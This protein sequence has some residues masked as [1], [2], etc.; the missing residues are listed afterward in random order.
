MRQ[1]TAE[2]SALVRGAYLTASLILVP[3]LGL[4]QDAVMSTRALEAGAVEAAVYPVWLP[5]DGELGGLAR[6]AWR[7]EDAVQLRGHLGFFDDLAYFG[8]SAEI[9]VARVESFAIAAVLGLHRSDFDAAADILGFDASLLAR[10]DAAGL[11]FY[12]SV[13][14]DFERPEEPFDSFTRSH[15][16]GGL[17][18]KL[19]DRIQLVAEGGLGFNDSS[20][21]Y[22]SAGVALRFD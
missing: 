3:G 17:S 15:L 18:T 7:V 21:D 8:A 20:P 5:G 10:R 13:D 22:L 19:S 11:S 9:R 12:A 1:L 2:G 4:A 14:L 16:V 6:G